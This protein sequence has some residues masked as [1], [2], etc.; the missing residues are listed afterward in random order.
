MSENN[1]RRMGMAL[2]TL[3]RFE[4]LEPLSDDALTQLSHHMRALRVPRGNRVVACGD[5]ARAVYFLLEGRVKVVQQ[6]A[7]GREL[8]LAW[9][10]AGE[11]FGE[12]ALIDDRPRSADV[13]TVSDSLLLLLPAQPARA[14]LLDNPEVNQRTMRR[15]VGLVRRDNEQRTL[16]GTG[17]A[18]Q[19]VC[20]FLLSLAP[21]RPKRE[22]WALERSLTHEAIASMTDTTRETVSRAFGW[23]REQGIAEKR[24]GGLFITDTEALTRL[25]GGGPR[26]D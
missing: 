5:Q 20:A 21:E 18:F 9:L 23:L 14:V 19:R 7:N 2:S 15:L 1:P 16:L 13:I 25:A 26:A 11:C 4:L 24:D 10:D 8:G 6:T 3:R 17:N 12:M 22:G